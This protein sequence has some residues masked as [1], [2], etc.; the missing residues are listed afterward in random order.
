MFILDSLIY[1]ISVTVITWTALAVPIMMLS[2]ALVAY[3][4]YVTGSDR[5]GT[6][7]RHVIYAPYIGVV[8]KIIGVST[9]AL[10]NLICAFV[11]I[12]W[13]MGLLFTSYVLTKDEHTLL[14][15]IHE[16]GVWSVD[17][18][19]TAITLSVLLIVSSKGIKSGYAFVKKVKSLTEKGN[20]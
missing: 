15:S 5:I 14:S 17:N 2:L 19:S 9:K 10:P 16:L 18:L 11:V 3:L 7:Y 13:I 4:D 1:L 20:A 6:K 8:T 12:S